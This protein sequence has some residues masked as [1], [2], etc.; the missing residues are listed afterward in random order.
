MTNMQES[1]RKR[2]AESQKRKRPS[3]RPAGRPARRPVKRRAVQSQSII[4]E[5]EK[6]VFMG[7]FLGVCILLLAISIMGGIIWQTSDHLFAQNPAAVVEEDSQTPVTPPVYDDRYG[8]MDSR[9]TAVENSL[10]EWQHRLWM[11]ALATNENAN[12]SR[13]VDRTYHRDHDKQYM[14]LDADW[15]SNKFPETLSLTDKQ[16]ESF[17]TK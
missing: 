11:V 3:R 1:I 5:K 9:V 6:P 12:L 4:P 17:D 16:R 2:V 8:T 14:T 10:K 13:Q 7:I 15:Q